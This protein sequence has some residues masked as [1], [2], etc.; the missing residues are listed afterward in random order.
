P[1]ICGA[2]RFPQADER[3][4]EVEVEH[5]SAD[6][7][8]FILQ[9]LTLFPEEIAVAAME[10]IRETTTCDE[11]TDE[12]GTVFTLGPADAPDVGDESYA[13]RVAFQV[14]D[15]GV[16]E[17]EFVFVRVG[18]YVTIV[19]TLGFDDYD[20]EQSAAVATLAASKLRAGTSTGSAITDEEEALIELLL[21]L[22]DVPDD[23]DQ[24]QSA[25]RSDPE[26]WTGLCDSNLFPAAAEAAAR[27]A[28]ELYE[29][30]EA[31][32]ASLQQLLVNYPSDVAEQA[33]EYEIEA[34]S[35]AEFTRGDTD[36]LLELDAEFPTLGDDS[37]AVRFTLA[38]DDV[39]AE[40]YWIVIRAGGALTTLIYTDP[41]DLDVEEVEVIARAAAERL[42][43][44]T[45]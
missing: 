14:A 2:E 5:Q 12:S 37:F 42:G 41:S 25:H 39:D 7:A 28:V 34:A 20:P 45:S 19:T 11:W 43:A 17:G 13:L 30:F 4:A 8:R 10:Y 29:G 38:G 33:Y 1:G 35:C 36:V 15:A 24:L 6:H 22:S 21:T 26:S 3:I 23:W 16:L 44:S 40:G 18:G 31:D 27:V 9:S 32:S